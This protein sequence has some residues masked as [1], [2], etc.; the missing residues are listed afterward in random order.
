MKKK[1]FVLILC[2]LILLAHPMVS[3]EKNCSGWAQESIVKAKSCGFISELEADWDFREPM[4]RGEIVPIL[5]RAY[6]TVTGK[7][8]PK[9]ESLLFSDAKEAETSV[10]LLGI[11]NGV[12]NGLFSPDSLITREQIAKIILTVQAVCNNT[13]LTLPQTF[14]NAFGDFNT[15]SGWAKPYV[16]KAYHEGIVAG[17]EDGCFHGEKS[18]S[19]EEAVALVVRAVPSV[20]VIQETFV[21][22]DHL[23]WNVE[24]S[25][26]AGEL[27]L[28]WSLVRDVPYYTLTVTEQRN[29]RYEGD[30]PPNVQ[31]YEYT[32]QTTHT[33]YLYPN[34]T[35][36]LE[37]TAGEETLRQEFYV[38]KLKLSDMASIDATLP[39]T[40][41]EADAIMT[42]VTVPVWK[43]NAKGEKTESQISLTVHSGIAER[44]KLVFEEIFHGEEK[45]P[46]KDAGAYAWR[47]GRSEHNSGT[48]IDL[49]ANENYCIYKDGTTIGTFWKPYEDPY[50][51][52]PYGDVVNA[53][54]KYGFTWGGDAWSNPKDYMHFSY[55]GT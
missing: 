38:P 17:Y 30:I 28:Q 8:A 45:A 47:G 21:Y 49:N 39:Q 43:L 14:D 34:R 46:I 2:Y 26:E 51:F 13:Q 54:E 44:V 41:E 3:A 20:T 31:V 35:Y 24:D 55:L 12:G 27:T 36:T 18:V 50:S 33:L 4:T 23:T 52:T 53:F 10:S 29:S 15:V 11:M 42:T 6:E 5:L 9:G 40:K 7:A 37:L 25:Y 32:N 16:E 48:A 22:S 19:K 1:I